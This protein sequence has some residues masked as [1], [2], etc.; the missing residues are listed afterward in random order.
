MKFFCLFDKILSCIVDFA[1]C[2]KLI[3]FYNCS[4]SFDFGGKTLFVEILNNLLQSIQV[5]DV[6]FDSKFSHVLP[7]TLQTSL[8]FVNIK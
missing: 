5:T 4:V 3:A 8:Y 6:V 2:I 7:F 1:F